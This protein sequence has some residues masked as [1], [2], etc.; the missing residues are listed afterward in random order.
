MTG[1][2]AD[3]QDPGPRLNL[4]AVLRGVVAP[5]LA[6][7][8][9]TAVVGRLLTG[10]LR[11]FAAEDAILRLMAAN[12]TPARNRWATSVSTAS[13]VA[14]AIALAVASGAVVARTT[15]NPR[16]AAA[17][18]AAIAL[19]TAV[20]VSAAAIVKRPRPDVPKLGYEHATT[21]FPSGHTGA[22]VALYRTW[23]TLLER[24]GHPAARVAAPVLRVVAPAA[25]AH[26][27]L[28]CGMHHPSD[29]AA[30]ALIG[31]WSAHAVRELLLPYSRI[32][33]VVR[34]AGENPTTVEM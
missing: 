20:F 21:S 9:V 18:L 25:V 24:S 15:R 34:S 1:Q 10:P 30:G 6:V 27:R 13:G 23:A 8:A 32:G 14:A 19:E 31:V 33:S 16:A 17:P 2:S 28:H 7:T 22:A 11:G 29:V 3:L 5:A 26:A 12:R 4:R